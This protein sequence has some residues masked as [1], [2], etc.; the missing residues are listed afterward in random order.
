MPGFFSFFVSVKIQAKT[1]D[2]SMPVPELF[3]QVRRRESSAGL[4]CSRRICHR[5]LRLRRDLQ[6]IYA[7][8]PDNVLY[9]ASCSVI[10]QAYLVSLDFLSIANLLEVICLRS[11]RGTVEIIIP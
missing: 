3:P 9:F 5:L 4:P 7:G 8:F 6:V 10:A 2:R 1:A 11:G